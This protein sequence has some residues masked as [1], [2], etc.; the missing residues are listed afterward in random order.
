MSGKSWWWLSLVLLHA[1]TLADS[2]DIPMP[3]APHDG[4]TLY[5]KCGRTYVGEL[6]LA[7]RR[8]VS[9]RTIGRCGKAV[10]TTA[11]PVNGWRRAAG[12][13]GVWVA[14]LATRPTQ[15][16][17]D[18]RFVPQAHHPNRPQTWLRA[19]R[20]GPRELSVRLPESD[21]DSATLVWRAADWLIQTRPIVRYDG[22]ILELAPGD[23]EGF[24]L[25]PTTEFYVEGKRWMIDSPGEWAWEAGQL[26]LRTPDGKSPEGRIRA[27][28]RARAI[29]ASGSRGVHIGGVRIIGA[30]L[31]IDGTDSRDLRI[32][33]T[34][35][36]D[37][38]EEAI[39]AGTGTRIERIH[40]RGSVQNGI[41]ANDDVR[42]VHITDS[43][44]EGIGMLGMPRRSKGAIVFEHARDVVIQRNHIA[45]T[46][47]IAIRVFRDA[48]VAD[49]VIERACLRLADCGG[50]YTFARDRQP[51]N[52]V[53]Q[54]NR[55]SK[56]HGRSSYAIYLDDFANGVSVIANQLI[57]NPGGI[58]L[59]NGF[60]NTIAGNTFVNS[61]H[62][63]MLFN[64]TATF[65]SV[66][67]NRVHENRFMSAGDVPVY[68]LWSHHGSAHVGRFASFTNN[69]YTARPAKFAEVEGYGMLDFDGWRQRVGT[70]SDARVR[71]AGSSSAGGT[72][73]QLTRQRQ[74][75]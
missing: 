47:Y 65:A 49:N 62:E 35:I 9:I 73:P 48:V 45:D 69:E 33:D 57:D 8:D 61:R 4:E 66:T 54:R 13:S 16:A 56:L 19:E 59:H 75:K 36:D 27:S 72:P 29:D 74:E 10:L 42:D 50:V 5:L 1:A 64:E 21:L 24:G 6:S 2:S 11:R 15:I 22:R 52:V 17:L 71:R 28:S 32:T 58:Q 68:R 60:D 34:E 20:R 40:V 44:F 12:L 67:G 30:T 25:L 39:L 53:I 26:F 55:I 70:E 18:D 43:H 23:D 7:S 37:S 51:L 41:R 63:H 46:G 3:L 14:D 31:A 38:G